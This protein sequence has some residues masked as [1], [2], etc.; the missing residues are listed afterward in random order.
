MTFTVDQL[1]AQWEAY[2]YPFL[3]ISAVLVASPIFGTQIIPPQIKALLAVFLTI[4][5]SP[6]VRIDGVIDP[7]SAAGVLIA[8]E[9]ILIGLSIGFMIRMIFSV[10]EVGGYLIAQSMGLGF[11]Q[12]VD[13]TNGTAVPSVSQFFTIMA[14]LIFLALNGH[15]LVVQIAVESF[16]AIP[17]GVSLGGYS[18]W[19]LVEWSSWIFKG[20]LIISLPVVSSLIMVQIA[21]GIMSRAAPQ[22]NVFSIGFPITLLL[23]FVFLYVSIP[24]FSE[25][26]IGIMTSAFDAIHMMLGGTHG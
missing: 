5:V 6:F 13:P 8:A 18:L 26:F 2:L 17:V 11:A 19:E 12:M 24:M 25:Q 10:M 16:T 4:M 21:F 22:L 15:V 3:R 23:G 1:V 9:Q 20:A 14:T 7:V